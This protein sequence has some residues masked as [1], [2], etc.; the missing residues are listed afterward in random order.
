[1]KVEVSKHKI[2]PEWWIYSTFPAN[3]GH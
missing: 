2:W 1:M 3:L